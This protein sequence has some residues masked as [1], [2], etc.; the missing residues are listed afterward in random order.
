[1]IEEQAAMIK[2]LF[3]DH[4]S[5]ST[6]PGE[7]ELAHLRSSESFPMGSEKPFMLERAWAECQGTQGCC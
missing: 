6:I 1:M 3:S 7:L 4:S 5:P 2:E